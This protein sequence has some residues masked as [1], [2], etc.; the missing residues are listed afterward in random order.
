MFGVSLFVWL[1][2]GKM[3]V[4]V[5]G[6]LRIPFGAVIPLRRAK[7]DY[8]GTGERSE[9]TALGGAERRGQR[10]T[11]RPRQNPTHFHS[12]NPLSASPPQRSAQSQSG[13]LDHRT[14]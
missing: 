7:R 4:G 1:L 6:V 12:S 13:D 10:T 14:P 3:R 11:Q 5:T 8:G 2:G 9:L